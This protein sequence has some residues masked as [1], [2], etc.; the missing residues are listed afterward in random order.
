MLQRYKDV[1][2][3]QSFWAKKRGA[4]P[5][6]D[7]ALCCFIQDSPTLRDLDGFGDLMLRLSLRHGDVQDAFNDD[8]LEVRIC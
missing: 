2:N 8:G 6:V 3:K 7:A 5:A 1:L 4:T